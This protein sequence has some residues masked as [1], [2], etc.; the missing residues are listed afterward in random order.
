[1]TFLETY[2]GRKTAFANKLVSKGVS[3][4]GSDGLT[5]LINKIDEIEHQTKGIVLTGNK[6][7]LQS[8]ERFYA[9]AFVMKDDGSIVSDN[10]YV[11]FEGLIDQT[12]S[13]EKLIINISLLLTAVTVKVLDWF[14]SDSGFSQ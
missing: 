6:H 4:S 7:I 3:A 5:T 13:F 2:Q 9:Y 12:I 11:V 10:T 8:G 1:M 14:I